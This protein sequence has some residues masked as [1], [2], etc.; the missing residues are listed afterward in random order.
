MERLQDSYESIAAIA[1]Y[2]ILQMY[3]VV[4]QS[5][6]LFLL[7]SRSLSHISQTCAT[8]IAYVRCFFQDSAIAMGWSKSERN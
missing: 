5:Y 1:R 3:N 4:K 8:A 7:Q 2:K 6:S